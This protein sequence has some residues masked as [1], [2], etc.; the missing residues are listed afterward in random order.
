MQQR[1][2]GEEIVCLLKGENVG[3]KSTVRSLDPVLDEDG[4]MRVGGRLTNATI[5]DLRR[6]PYVVPHGS[7]I[8]KLI[9]REK[10]EISH[11]GVEWVVSLIRR[12]F[13]I[14]RVRVIVKSIIS[15]CF[16]CRK[17]FSAPLTQK[18][19]NLP[20]ERIDAFKPPFNS[21][22][23]VCIINGLYQSNVVPGS[24]Q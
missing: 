19:A 4:L 11:S 21:T 15:D 16:A 23:V 8:A 18:M 5:D 17:M 22:G 13:W 10:H 7:P 3:K 2:Y 12:K 20:F 1:Y 6:R 9:A 14:T 24:Q